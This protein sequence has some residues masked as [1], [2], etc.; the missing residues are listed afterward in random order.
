MTNNKKHHT[1]QTKVCVYK[2]NKDN[3]DIAIHEFEEF[4][5]RREAE[6]NIKDWL[7]LEAVGRMY[8]EL[9]KIKTKQENK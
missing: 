9:R 2:V 1:I 3:V 6:Y 5:K 4:C 8:N 7:K